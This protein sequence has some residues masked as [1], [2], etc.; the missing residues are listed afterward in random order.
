LVWGGFVPQKQL[1]PYLRGFAICILPHL[2]N[3]LVR[4]SN[5]L[6]IWEYLAT[7]KP[8]VSI[9][10][11]A[12]NAVREFVDVARDHAHFID[13]VAERVRTGPSQPSAAAQAAAL[14][15]SWNAIFQRLLQKLEPH[16][17]SKRL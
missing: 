4:R 13:L 3:E 8:I 1:A 16:L 10:L 11:P 6:K 17:L 15:Y 14:N 5:P 9:D 12:L 2:T 7:G